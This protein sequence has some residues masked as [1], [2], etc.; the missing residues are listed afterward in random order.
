MTNDRPE[1]G[2]LGRLAGYRPPDSASIPD[3]SEIDDLGEMTDTRIYEGELES[4]TPDSDQPDESAVERLD[5]LVSTEA[6]AGETDDPYEAAE[7][8]LA[9]I[10]PVDPPVRAGEIGQPEVAAGFG[11][12][13]GDEPFDLD[14]HADALPDEDERT[15]R[16]VEALRA[17][18]STAAVADRIDVDTDGARVVLSGSVEDIYD[19]EAVLAVASSVTGIGDV[20]NRL[21]VTTLGERRSRDAAPARSEGD[22]A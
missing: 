9:W 21:A 11:T 13:A 19:E 3:A 1:E 4:R 2:D 20:E 12:T 14:H 7:E 6:R 5:L 10:P 8:G 15:A 17:D 22:Q 16:V 18:A